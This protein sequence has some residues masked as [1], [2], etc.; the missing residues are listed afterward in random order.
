MPGVDFINIFARL[1]RSKNLTLFLTNGEPRTVEKILG[2]KFVKFGT[3]VLKD[4]VGEIEQ[5]I[6]S[7]T[8][9]AGVILL[10][11]KVWQNQLQGLFARD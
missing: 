9:C 11:K 2:Q 5:Q 8:L 6:F 4:N 10:G 7:Q 1:F 3:G